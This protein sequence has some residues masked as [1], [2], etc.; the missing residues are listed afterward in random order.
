MRQRGSAIIAM[1]L[2]SAAIDPSIA[3]TLVRDISAAG[4]I[5]P[6]SIAMLLLG[7]GAILVGLLLVALVTLR[8]SRNVACADNARLRDAN[9]A[10]EQALQLRTEFLATTSHEIR[11]PLNGI[12]GMTQVLLA[13]DRVDPQVR[14]KIHVVHGAGETMKSLVDDILDTAKMETGNV[15]IDRAPMDLHRLLDEAGQL[16]R[17][18]AQTKGVALDLQ[19]GGCPGMIEEDPARLRQVVFNLMSNALKF[20]EA[21]SVTLSAIAERA[22][23][24]ERL[25]IKVRDTGI[26]IAADQQARIFERFWQADGSIMRRFGGTGLGL[27]ICRTLCEAM[28]GTLTLQSRVGE[29]STFTASFP[30]RRL[31]APDAAPILSP[32]EE[33]ASSLSDAA[34]LLVEPNPLT[35]RIMTRMLQSA[36]RSLDVV[37][38]IGPATERIERGG[39]DH[40]LIELPADEGDTSAIERLVQAAE[41]RQVRVSLLFSPAGCTAVAA[42]VRAH[43][44]IVP[45]AKPIAGSALIRA[46]EAPYADAGPRGRAER[47][48]DL[49]L[50]HL[51]PH[52]ENRAF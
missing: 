1:V 30:L 36:V 16:W 51:S 24:G 41:Q 32:G 49:N 2:A 42:L 23:D 39:I 52:C 3:T 5:L 28:G 33:R 13:D 19:L 11:T 25:V 40:L 15:T 35:Q 22:G 18:L 43:P 17:A 46:L 20:T 27:T 48:S 10:L 34:L 38:A 14:E 7:A 9:E 44:A 21:G 47:Q 45:I 26:G 4:T 31:G 8:T 37:T 12:L 6:G 50:P 29:G